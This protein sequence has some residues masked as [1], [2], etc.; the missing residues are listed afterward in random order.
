MTRTDANKHNI[1]VMLIGV[2]ANQWLDYC[3]NSWEADLLFLKLVGDELQLSEAILH[4]EE[5]LP[6]S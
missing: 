5:S 4:H 2:I 6:E 3:Y 1:E